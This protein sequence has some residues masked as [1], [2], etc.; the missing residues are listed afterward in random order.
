MKVYLDYYQKTLEQLLDKLN[1]SNISRSKEEFLEILLTRDALKKLLST[2]I[3]PS[4][5]V[6][7]KLENLDSQL[8]QNAERLIQFIDLAQYRENFPKSSDAWWWY[9][10][11][12][13]E[14]KARKSHPWNRF[15]WFFR[16]VRVLVWTGNLA[17]LGTLAALFLS[18]GSGFWGAVTIA[19]PS[20]L[21]LLQ[22]QS[23]LTE[24]GKKGFDKL[25]E[26]L[27]I[28]QEFHEEAKL[29]SSLLM[30]G[31]L[32]IIWLELPSISN[33]YKRGGKQDQDNQ[34]LALAEEKYLKAVELDPDNLDAHYKLATLYEELQDSANAKKQ[35]IIAAKGG[36]L[37]A[38][39]NLAYWYIR[40]NKNDEAVELLNKGLNILDKKESNDVPQEKRLLHYAQNVISGHA[41][42][43]VRKKRGYNN[44]PILSVLAIPWFSM[45]H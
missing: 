20:I 21:S 4:A 33:S 3:K 29:G 8:K 24:T 25:L 32:L 9:L 45:T 31:L 13:S 16:V 39:N 15:D 17:L 19:F 10:D 6:I 7:L 11:I 18:S 40:E 28:P 44:C 1:I 27:K 23:E 43:L 36:Y 41:V 14:E 26:R 35:Y 30:T 2:E 12:Y 37:D 42:L 38:Y 22:A 34:K 5:S